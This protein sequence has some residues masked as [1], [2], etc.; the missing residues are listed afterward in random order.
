MGVRLD[1]VLHQLSGFRSLGYP[2]RAVDGN[3]ALVVRGEP[4]PGFRVDLSDVVVSRQSRE[5]RF[6]AVNVAELGHQEF[7]IAEDGFGNSTPA[8]STFHKWPALLAVEEAPGLA[9]IRGGTHLYSIPVAGAQ[10]EVAQ[11][12]AELRL[13]AHDRDRAVSYMKERLQ[14]TNRMWR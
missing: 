7:W 14:W 10:T 13:P 9:F 12:V 4:V 1:P 3:L 2:V 8:G 6:I 11:F 5:S